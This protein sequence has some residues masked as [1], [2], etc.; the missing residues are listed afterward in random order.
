MATRTVRLPEE[1]LSQAT[2]V[3]GVLG[4]T[5]GEIF[6][7]ALDEYVESHRHEIQ[8]TWEMNQK[9]V[10]SQDIETMLQQAKAGRAEVVASAM[11]RMRALRPDH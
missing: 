10:L 6:A 5:P 1:A 3:A 2:V 7:S 9:L 8:D 4:R 11:A